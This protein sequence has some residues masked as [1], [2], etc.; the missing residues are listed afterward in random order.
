MAV[1]QLSSF[2]S[3]LLPSKS[4]YQRPTCLHCP[5]TQLHLP[6]TSSG[7]SS[8][9]ATA[10]HPTASPSSFSSLSA[11]DLSSIVYPAL[12]YSNTLFFKSAYNVQVIVGENEP[13]DK[14]LNRFRKEVLKAG[15]IQESK[16]R[17]FFENHHDKKKR[18]A[19]E[20]ARRNRKRRPQS[21]APPQNKDEA[22]KM[23]K[24]DEE[25]YDNWELPD[26]DAM[27]REM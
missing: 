4:S 9:V 11:S 12:A 22:P 8:L 26:V 7:W 17:R 27:E 20:A 25:E 16:R 2:F 13:E 14:L 3:S 15:V 5:P 21:R 19:R 6:Q 23:K 24:D 10:D 1:S 18:K